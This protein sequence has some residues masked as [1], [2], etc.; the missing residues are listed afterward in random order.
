MKTI[1]KTLAFAAFTLYSSAQACGANYSVGLTFGNPQPSY[2]HCCHQPY[3]GGYNS[4]PMTKAEG[5]ITGTILAI[6]AGISFI[7]AIGAPND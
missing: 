2:G 4:G 7:S 3:N 5:I 1:V 6:F